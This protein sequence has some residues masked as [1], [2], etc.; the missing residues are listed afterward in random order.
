MNVE[1]RWPGSVHDA[2]VF[3]NSNINKNLQKGKL[4]KHQQILPGRQKFGNH[5]IGDAAYA[6]TLYCLREYSTCSSNA[7]VVFNNVNV[8]LDD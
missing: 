6:L 2:K 4:P 5:L 1:C 3:C 7:E 8:A